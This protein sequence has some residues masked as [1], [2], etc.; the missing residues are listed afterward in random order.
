MDKHVSFAVC[1]GNPVILGANRVPAGM[2]FAL[3][4][5][6]E[7]KAALVLY[8][9]GGG[10]PF[11]ELPFDN[12]MRTGKRCAMLLNDF[13][14]KKFEYNFR[15]NGKIVQDPCAYGIMG[16]E[17]FGVL[18]NQEDEHQ[19]RCSFLNSEAYDWKGDI[20]PQIPYNEAVI[21]KVHVRGY[22]KQA[23]ITHKKRG[24]FAGLTEMIPY[25]KELGVNVIELMPAYEFCEISSASNENGFIIRK[26]QED[27]VN[28][29]GY[30]SG[31]YFAPKKSYCATSDSENEFR[32]MIR[33]MH[34]A[35]IEC[36]MEMYFPEDIAPLYALQAIWFWKMF[37]H[38][39]G[40]H[41]IGDGVPQQLINE[42][43]I[44]YGTKKIFMNISG[45]PDS[46]NMLAEYQT[47]FQQDMRR[48][49]KSDEG[50]V[51]GAEFHIRRNVGNFGTV[52]YMASQDGFTLYDTV[53][54]NYR[55][56]EANGEGNHDGID[57]NYSWNCGVEGFTRK[58]AVRKMRE[59]Q[60]RN[61]FLMLLLSQGTPMIYSGDEFGNSQEGNNNAW[62][63]D[64]PTGWTDWKAMKKNPLLFSFV[65]K[66]IAFRKEHPILHMKSEMRGVDY[67]AK[68]FPD[69]SFH[70]ERAWYLNTE[71]TS[72]LLGVMYCGE[73]AVR[74]DG[75]PD[76]FIYVGYNFHWETRSIALPNLPEHMVWK[77]YADTSEQA[78]DLWF[79]EGTEEFKKSIQISPRTI[80]VLI[81]EQEEQKDASMAALQND[82]KA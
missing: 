2:N 63:Q 5:P 28:Y 19:I 69:I 7:A 79:K 1:K 46:S 58:Q 55:H 62:C 42:D 29:W 66:A 43:H 82:H 8:R 18:T 80:V 70:G 44:L 14:D 26:Q 10:V 72:R 60:L 81:A 11:R 53:S 64:N 56:N 32:D 20:L 40:F 52:N 34:E 35:G 23:R 13:N 24:T 71:N 67:M 76:D 61:A 22:T 68:G 6:V 45:N 36:I 4:V 25:W 30:V 15:I 47:G 73:Y 48:F 75:S 21:Y 38:V 16:R 31:F 3:E 9:K 57:Y 41:L 65:K 33:A 74:K 77:K 54:Y 59:Q 39:D 78:E 51:Q 49:L 12:S 27:R 50:M 17:K 37:Y